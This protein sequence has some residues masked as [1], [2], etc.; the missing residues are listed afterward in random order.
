MAF[1]G[2]GVN[3]RRSAARGQQ[4]PLPPADPPR[5]PS[6]SPLSPLSQPVPSQSTNPFAQ[7][8]AAKGVSYESR[9]VTA[10][11]EGPIG[12]GSMVARRAS[13]NPFARA[14]DGGSSSPNPHEGLQSSTRVDLSE[15]GATFLSD[16]LITGL[17]YR[18]VGNGAPLVRTR[19][20]F[21]L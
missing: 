9:G 11:A 15:T 17:A 5:L 10:P 20:D 6:A 21:L 16:S 3:S 18:L 7:R 14:A 19:S 8:P 12:E 13:S 2:G 4:Q 1:Y